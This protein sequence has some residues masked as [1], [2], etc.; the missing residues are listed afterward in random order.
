MPGI[1]YRSMQWIA[2]HCQSL[3]ERDSMFLL[4]DQ[5]FVRVPFKFHR[6]SY[7]P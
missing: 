2:E 4:I 3:S 6:L 1:F 5:I 7:S